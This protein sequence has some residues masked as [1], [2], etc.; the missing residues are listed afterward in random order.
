MKRKSIIALVLCLCL[1]FGATIA[2]AQFFGL[3][4][5]DP[6]VYAE[7]VAQVSQLVKQYQ[8]LV[9]TYNQITNQYNQMLFLAQRVPVDMLARYRAILTPWRNS[10]ATNTYG[11]TGGWIG[12][13]NSGVNVASG[14]L[15]A[16]DQ[17]LTYGAALNNVPADQ[18][19]RVKRNYASVEL[20]DGSNIHSI[21]TIGTLRRNASQVETTIAGLEQDSL[22]ADPNMNTE[23]AVLNK[24]NASSIIAL[25]NSQDTNKVLV[26]L[27]EQQVVQ[28]KQQRDGESR[29]INNHIQFMGQE[30]AIL[31][32]QKAGTT[33][34]MLDFRM[35]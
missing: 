29:A 11:T 12:A 18:V 9:Q 21:E 13:I 19:D 33:A 5:F 27:A 10:T 30:Q 3:T 34:A 1:M 6:T 24:I 35:P 20:T 16:A 25:R 7:A 23:V 8:Q 4:V 22:S 32:D 2:R 14:Y 28:S 26:A 17:L 31:T 15:D